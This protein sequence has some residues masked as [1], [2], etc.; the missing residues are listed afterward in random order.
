MKTILTIL[1]L[2]TF[3]LGFSQ[4]DTT[5][6]NPL[7]CSSDNKS[8]LYYINKP[9]FYNYFHTSPAWNMNYVI[10]NGRTYDVSSKDGFMVILLGGIAFTTAS[11]LEGGGNYGTWT[12]TPTTGSPYNQTYTT[13]PFLQQTPR[14]I[15]FFTGVGLT[16]TGIIGL[17]K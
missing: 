3:R 17:C 9:N 4:Q 8:A 10:Q 15:M 6:T 5:K 11:I 14:N 13:K 1:L 16:L 2:L 12:S 7:I